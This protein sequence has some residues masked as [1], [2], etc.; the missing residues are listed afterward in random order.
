MMGALHISRSWLKKLNLLFLEGGY[1][2]I[3]TIQFLFNVCASIQTNG[4]TKLKNILNSS[5]LGKLKV[6]TK[7]NFGHWKNLNF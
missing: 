7:L 4:S 6:M 1:L 3:R 2:W 5:L